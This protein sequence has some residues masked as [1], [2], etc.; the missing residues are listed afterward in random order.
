MNAFTACKGPVVPRMGF[1]IGSLLANPCLP[2][3]AQLV[4]RVLRFHI[5]AMCMS[6]C[7]LV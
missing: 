1:T 7:V 6:T 5:V 3:E 4:C 2:H